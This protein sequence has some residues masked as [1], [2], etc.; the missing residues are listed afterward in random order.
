MKQQ[1][2]EKNLQ[3]WFWT[4]KEKMVDECPEYHGTFDY[5]VK[6]ADENG[7]LY[8]VMEFAYRYLEV[9]SKSNGGWDTLN[10]KDYLDAIDYG[11]TNWVSEWNFISDN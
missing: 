6:N 7:V 4:F 8:E 1:I 2:A 10:I 11:Y 5:I 9:E 3:T